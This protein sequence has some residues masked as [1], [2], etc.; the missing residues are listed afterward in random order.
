MDLNAR[1][2]PPPIN[3]EGLYVMCSRVP[4]SERLRL[5]P[6]QPHQAGFSHLLKLKRNPDLLAWLNAFDPYTGM[7]N[8]ENHDLL[9]WMMVFNF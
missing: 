2:F 4:S 7:L 9:H 1:P 3:L 5:M 8:A 6:P